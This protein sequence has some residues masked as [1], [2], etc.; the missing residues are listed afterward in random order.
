MARR[1]RLRR[2]LA[3]DLG[4]EHA[5]DIVTLES[6]AGQ[7]VLGQKKPH[8]LIVGLVVDI[9]GGAEWVGRLGGG[10]RIPEDRCRLGPVLL[11]S[12]EFVDFELRDPTKGKGVSYAL[13][14]VEGGGLEF[15]TA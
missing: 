2:W 3:T 11:S 14:R 5:D 13:D 6:K 12:T 9:D 4:V 15:E 8:P 1:K 10:D 7:A